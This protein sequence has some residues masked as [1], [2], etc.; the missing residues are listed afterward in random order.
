MGALKI[1]AVNSSQRGAL[2]IEV[3]I[4]IAIVAIGLAG[5]SLMQNR[6]QASEVESYQRT[7]AMMLANDMVNRI[8]TNRVNAASY[9]IGTPTDPASTGAGSV[10]ANPALATTVQGLDEAEWCNAL[11][12]AAEVQS[13]TNVG[14]LIGGRGC[15]HQ[16]GAQE[17]MVTVVWQGLTPISS[18]TVICGKESPNPYD[19]AT[20]SACANDMCRRSVSTTV[21]FGTLPP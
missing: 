5:L 21:R 9:V 17:Y 7:Q 4:T 14:A 13:S 6:L 11:Q 8:S 20:G 15:V 19:G 10:C 16:I 12:G 2:M 1:S 18:P 3:L